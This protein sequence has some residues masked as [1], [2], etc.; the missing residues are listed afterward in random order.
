MTIIMHFGKRINVDATSRYADL[1]KNTH[2]HTGYFICGIKMK[3]KI[4]KIPHC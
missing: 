4:P 1:K 2:A 3:K